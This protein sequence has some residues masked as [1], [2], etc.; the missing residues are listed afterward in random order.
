MAAA[1]DD[2]IVEYAH[3]ELSMDSAFLISNRSHE[4][5]VAEGCFCYFKFH[6]EE[7]DR[8]AS[9]CAG[10]KCKVEV[11]DWHKGLW[12][13]PDRGKALSCRLCGEWLDIGWNGLLN[14]FEH[15]EKKHAVEKRQ[16]F[17]AIMPGPDGK[18]RQQCPFCKKTSLEYE[19]RVC[20]Y[21]NWCKSHSGKN[22]GNFWLDTRMGVT[23]VHSDD[24][25][26]DCVICQFCG[27]C[28]DAKEEELFDHILH[29]HTFEG[30][31]MA[32]GKR[33][34]MVRPDEVPLLLESTDAKQTGRLTK[35]V[36]PT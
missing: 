2:R 17:P 31:K 23:Y 36:A 32:V 1:S 20:C 18:E 13:L 3:Y 24:W 14:V 16:M 19:G 11:L 12:Y 29:E 9:K 30:L 33:V 6:W 25:M 34:R 21:N 35:A 15:M 10:E 28:V 8:L 4:E 5:C 7:D 27:D 26:V 22:N